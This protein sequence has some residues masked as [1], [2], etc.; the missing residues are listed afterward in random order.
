MSISSNLRYQIVAGLI[1]ER[2]IEKVFASNPMVSKTLTLMART[3]NT[4]IGSLLWVD[5]LRYSG[6]QKIPVP[7]KPVMVT[8]V[9][10][11]TKSKKGKKSKRRKN[12]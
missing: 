11:L 7:E 8:E 1:E 9:N 12:K 4:Y 2:F 6:L 5:F 3:I 10:S